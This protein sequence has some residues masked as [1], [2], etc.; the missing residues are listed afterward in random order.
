MAE[1]LRN[2][3]IDQMVAGSIPAVQIYV[4]SLG[5]AFHP[6]CFGGMSLYLL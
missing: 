3:T 6:T 4:V 1:Q 5:K 2:R